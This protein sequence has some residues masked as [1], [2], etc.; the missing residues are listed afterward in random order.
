MCDPS[1]Y[2]STSL[3]PL[4][5]N[6]PLRIG[7]AS[8]LAK[9]SFRQHGFCFSWLTSYVLKV[10]ANRLYQIL[11]TTGAERAVALDITD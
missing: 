2:R 5:V 9:F 6:E 8:H 7:P 4:F 11:D 1:N 3:R 10:I